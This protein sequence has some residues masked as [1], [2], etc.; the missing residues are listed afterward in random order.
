[1][2][3]QCVREVE[4]VSFVPLFMS[5]T[6]GMAKEATNFYKRLVLSLLI[7]GI[8]VQQHPVSESTVV[9]FM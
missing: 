3:E 4:H 7:N 8:R 6:G 2:Y 9:R 5:T 1:M